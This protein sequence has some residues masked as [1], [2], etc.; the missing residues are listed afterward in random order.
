M[1]V[2]VT[3]LERQVDL[4]EENFDLALRVTSEVCTALVARRRA[5]VRLALVTSPAYLDRHGRPP[6]PADL[7]QHRRLGYVHTGGGVEW[8]LLGPGG[9]CLVPRSKLPGGQHPHDRS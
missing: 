9:P 8:E 1:L 4:I 6:T 3:L 5:S 2:D 7:L